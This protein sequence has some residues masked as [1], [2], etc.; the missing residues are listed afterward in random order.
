MQVMSNTAIGAVTLSD[1]SAGERRVWMAAYA[2]VV[3]GAIAA[4]TAF[5][6]SVNLV[7]L[8]LGLLSVITGA[9]A[10]MLSTH[11]NQRWFAVVGA[12]AGGFGAAMGIGHGALGAL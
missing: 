3:L 4:L 9:S 8:I 1:R 10:Q 6:R 12:I 7:G 11:T 5:S 2:T